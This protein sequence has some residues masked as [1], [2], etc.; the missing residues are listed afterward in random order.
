MSA[1]PAA[2]QR[3]FVAAQGSDGNPCTFALP[4]RTFQHAH[5]VVAANGEIDVL[6][7]AGYGAV[8]ITKAISIQGH[9]FSGISVGGGSTAITVNAGA[10]DAVNLRGL[11]IDGVGSGN[12]G[13]TFN[14]GAALHVQDSVIRNFVN[15]GIN[16]VPVN[17]ESTLIVSDT[18]ISDNG[19]HGL[20]MKPSG[21][22]LIFVGTF[23]RVGANNNGT[24]G[25]AIIGDLASNQTHKGVNAIA[26]DCT[27][28][29][30]NYAS[31]STGFLTSSSQGIA[32]LSLHR[33]VAAGNFIGASATSTNNAITAVKLSQS[34]MELNRAPAS[35][36]GTNAAIQTYSDN[37]TGGIDI[38]PSAGFQIP[39]K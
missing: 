3:V 21:A 5:N 34:H 14:T 18:L 12:M 13:I 29:G 9:G 39:T 16:F 23:T 36:T 37:Y 22:G 7:P 1:T 24:S 17:T 32:V 4:C 31:T 38:V 2:A 28:V 8:T 20:I 19:V 6:D 10:T 11:L 26:I 15:N 30:R 33:S 25:I 27:A 35:A